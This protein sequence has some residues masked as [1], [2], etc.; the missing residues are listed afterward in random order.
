MPNH[1]VDPMLALEKAVRVFSGNL[2]GRGLDSPFGFEKID[3]LHLEFA[4]LRPARVHPEKHRSPVTALGPAGTGVNVN[5]GIEMIGLT[6]QEFQDSSGFVLVLDLFVHL[7]DFRFE[8]LVPFRHG[9]FEQCLNVVQISD[10]HFPGFDSVLEAF[11]P[12]HHF[13]GTF[14]ISPKGGIVSHR[15]LVFYLLADDVG[16]KDASRF[17]ES[18]CPA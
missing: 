9:K 2:E 11:D 5:K 4:P 14:L 3:N 16:V 7:P 13:L 15:L 12:C 17:R 8:T 18:L 1:A 6:R 10:Q